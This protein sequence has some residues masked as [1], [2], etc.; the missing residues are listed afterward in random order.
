MIRYQ[1]L[2]EYVGTSF[3]G[4]Q[5][6]KKG[7]SIQKTIQN[8]LS[9]LLKEKISLHGSGRTDKGVHALGQ[10]INFRTSTLLEIDKINNFLNNILPSDV[11]L[12]TAWEEKEDFHARFSAKSRTYVYKML[13]TSFRDSFKSRYFGFYDLDL[14]VFQEQMKKFIGRHN[15]KY[16]STKIP[17]GCP[18]EKSVN[19]ISFVSGSSFNVKIKANSFLRGM[20]RIMIGTSI[21]VMKGNL[22]PNF[23]ESALEDPNISEKKRSVDASGLY[24]TS[25]DF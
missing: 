5:T 14:D 21:A 2:I 16:F 12:L 18:V 22:A 25:V 8:V 24:F 6:Q 10:V 13:P 3:I 20:I 15:F 19:E 11:R 4:W 1:L 7:K 23:I 17:I 9:N